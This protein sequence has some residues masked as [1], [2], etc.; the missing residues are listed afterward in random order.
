MK[1]FSI[2]FLLFFSLQAAFA[3]TSVT[4][5]AP[6]GGENWTIG[7]PN[8]IQW[9]TSTP[10]PVKI[11]LY[12]D[13]VFYMT[14]CS[15]AASNTNSY[16][17]TP[18]YSVLPAVTYK[19]KITTLNNIPGYDYSDNSFS[20]NLGF[21]TV[22]SPNGG[23]IWQYGSTHLIQW[24]YNLCE[25]VRIELWKGGQYYS[26]LSASAPC[27]GSFAWAITN[28]IPA[29]NDYKIKIISVLATNGSTNIVYDFSDADF[30]IGSNSQCIIV[31]TPNGGEFW[32]RGHTYNISWIDCNSAPVRIELW[33][34]GNFFT[35]IANSYTGG[36]F[37]WTIP[38]TIPS[39]NDYKI[40][41]MGNSNTSSYDFS[42]NTFYIIGS[43]A[44]NPMS[45]DQLVQVY[46]NPCS[47]RLTLKFLAAIPGTLSIEVM[48]LSGGTAVR[49]IKAG[50]LENEVYS[51][52]TSNLG[53]GGYVLLLKDNEQVLSRTL[54]FVRQ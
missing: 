52:N 20:I 6:N 36:P 46:P 40:K 11:E 39:G 25:N 47:D 10:C 4:V 48:K 33:K 41:V 44:A 37:S 14:I 2:I 38:A 50:A 3:V 18:P 15:Q 5:I 45:P 13:G 31:L 43:T 42:D 29:G 32:I 35:L 21:L 16:T 27:N 30:T 7:C 49:E 8:T 28:S 12:K 53:N 9:V 17:W 1:K 54:F 51:L 23:E 19:V 34:A 24:N 26:L 22:L